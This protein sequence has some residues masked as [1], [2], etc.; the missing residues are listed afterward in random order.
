MISYVENETDT[1]FEFSVQD[2]V[3]KVMNQVL[4]MEGCP[5]DAEVNVLLT[6]NEGIREYNKNYRDIDRE[7]DV[8]SFPNLEYENPSDFSFVE[9]SA[10][11]SIDPETGLLML[12]DIIL[13]VDRIREQAAQ[14]EHSELRELAFLTAHSMLH[15]CGYDHMTTPEASVMEE[16]QEAA[17]QALGITRD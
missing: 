16:K 15:L 5:Y 2:V 14:Y 3:D 4:Q 17:L 8:L 1:V 11:D 9:K 13:S 6:D 12:G 10:A 7:T